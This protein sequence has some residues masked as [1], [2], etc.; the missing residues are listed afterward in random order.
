MNT[1]SR[2]LAVV[3][4]LIVVAVAFL[5]EMASKPLSEM[6]IDAPPLD[7]VVATP[8]PLTLAHRQLFFTLPPGSYAGIVRS[9]RHDGLINEHTEMTTWWHTYHDHR[10]FTHSLN[11]IQG[12]YIGLRPPDPRAILV[13][14]SRDSE[15]VFT[16]NFTPGDSVFL[17]SV[18]DTV[19]AG[20]IREAAL[21]MINER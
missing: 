11:V 2:L 15:E 4:I 13:H 19:F 17:H 5:F 3:F 21:G 6:S 9:M 7:S 8:P 12:P 14:V 1:T 20:M 18:H 16:Y 10:G